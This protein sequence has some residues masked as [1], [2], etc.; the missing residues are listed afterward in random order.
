MNDAILYFKNN[1]IKYDQIDNNTLKINNENYIICTNVPK[2]NEN[3]FYNKYVIYENTDKIYGLNIDKD[4]DDIELELESNNSDRAFVK[5]NNDDL[6]YCNLVS[7]TKIYNFYKKLLI[8][9]ILIWSNDNK[10]IIECIKYKNNVNKILKFE[11]I[12]SSIYV[13]DYKIITYPYYP[14]FNIWIDKIPNIFLLEKKNDNLVIKLLYIP[15][16][17]YDFQNIVLN[18]LN[19]ICLCTDKI[20]CDSCKFAVKLSRNHNNFKHDS[21]NYYI[22]DI[23]YSGLFLSFSSDIIKD[24]FIYD[25]ILYGGKERII[26]LNNMINNNDKKLNE[27]IRLFDKKKI[28]HIPFIEP[29]KKIPDSIIKYQYKYLDLANDLFSDILNV[30]DFEL[31]FDQKNKISNI[32]LSYVKLYVNNIKNCTLKKND[33]DSE[34]YKNQISD[35]FA[36]NNINIY[37][38]LLLN[39]NIFNFFIDNYD[40]LL[41]LLEIINIYNV[42]NNLCIIYKNNDINCQE[43]TKLKQT[44]DSSMYYDNSIDSINF[45]IY[46]FESLAGFF[47][48]PAQSKIF[49][50]ILSD[51]NNN[52]CNIYQM[53]MGTGKTSTITPLL[54]LFSLL[55]IDKNVIINCPKHLVK[56]TYDLLL[57]KFMPLL[58][59][60]KIHKIDI[61]RNDNGNISIY[62]LFTD[63]HKNIIIL[64]EVSIKS[65]KLNMVSN[66]NKINDEK[67]LLEYIKD[68]FII[69]D[70]I[71]SLIEPLKSDLNFPLN[72]PIINKYSKIAFDIMFPILYDIYNYKSTNKSNINLYA[73]NLIKSDEYSFANKYF[74]YNYAKNLFFG[75]KLEWNNQYDIK[76][77]GII[78]KILNSIISAIHLTYN[79]NFGFGDII[80]DKTNGKNYLVAIPYGAI[81]F[82]I[83]GSEFADPE[84]TIA[85]T[86]IS[87]LNK[88]LQKHN[89]KFML[90]YCNYVKIKYSTI[91]KIILFDYF[92]I[93]ETEILCD[94]NQLI[95]CPTDEEID[96]VFDKI[97]NNTQL[98]KLYIQN[99]ILEKYIKIN[100]EQYNCSYIDII[101]DDFTNLKTGYSGTVNFLVPYLKDNGF[102]FNRDIITDN[103]STGGIICAILGIINPVKI[104]P[105][106][107]DPD[108]II[109][110][111]IK[112]DISVFIDT[113]AFFTKVQPVD[114]IKKI[115]QYSITINC[116]KYKNK[117][118]IFIDR[119]TSKKLL[120]FD[121][122]D[123]IISVHKDTIYTHDDIFMYYDNKNIVGA[124]IKQSYKLI[125]LATISQNCRYTNT[126]QGI[127][128]LRNLNYGHIIHFL[129]SN[130]IQNISNTIDLFNFLNFNE[131][132]YK[133]M[134]NKKFAVQNLKTLTRYSKYDTE[135]YTDI[136]FRE[137]NYIHEIRDL[138]I[139]LYNSY[140][141]NLFDCNKT[142]TLFFKDLCT[143]FKNNINQTNFNEINVAKETEIETKIQI[144]NDINLITNI[145]TNNYKFSFNSPLIGKYKIDQ[146]I[147]INLQQCDSDI[148]KFLNKYNIFLS[149]HIIYIFN[150]NNPNYTNNFLPIY[151]NN[152]TNINHIISYSYI[153]TNSKILLISPDELNI[154]L[155]YLTYS[156]RL[157]LPSDL[158]IKNKFQ[159]VFYPKNKKDN[160]I[161]LS[162]KLLKIFLSVDIFF[163][164]YTEIFK[165]FDNSD[166][167]NFYKTVKIMSNISAPLYSEHIINFIK[168]NKNYEE[169]IIDLY[170]KKH[171]AHLLKLC[172]GFENINDIMSKN[173]IE[174][175]II[176]GK[177]IKK[178]SVQYNINI[179]NILSK[180]FKV[181]KY[182]EIIN[183]KY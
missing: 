131:E 123:Y 13:D 67:N 159:Y 32:E 117:K 61:T 105:H 53:L 25:C 172:I 102:H 176:F 103:V 47:V 116:D 146:Y 181:Y 40:I 130:E 161:N 127:F 65:L 139:D 16:N 119:D 62:N 57:N 26:L 63:D 154:I 83:N 178:N 89:I 51:I 9:D 72:E 80:N 58:H 12:N 77:I 91:Y 168:N 36:K 141:I 39:K 99:N 153:K 52:K 164:D 151:Y 71:D 28:E 73:N 149:P 37:N 124:D 101:S 120:Y 60:I 169:I 121:G 19:K 21:N 138:E 125:G 108:D 179:Q 174:N 148:F 134:N 15:H 137:I 4:L 24:Y 94:L 42:Y 59:N 162:E 69:I 114:F 35:I 107:T 111:I 147:N 74:E 31:K 98:I 90:D 171:F 66:F 109:K 87:Y 92:N 175:D 11:Y 144:D 156:K 29:V 64:D 150:K 10:C 95:E 132:N 84:L 170:N 104:I 133:G 45:I 112:N 27:L 5:K 8:D 93:F 135:L 1:N 115:I 152:S 163:Y 118:Y 166:Y 180:I 100:T 34:K 76:I 18:R 158:F 165:N 143:I 142:S 182:K 79:E 136:V 128:R 113:G 3:I 167:D 49:N 43:L 97:K 50:N 96:K 20:Q 183:L 140:I 129:I 177:I 155:Y 86:I 56:Q 173:I 54:V 46:L 41:S 145:V 48:R 110:T 23:H 14:N 160:D 70:E 17:N 157:N 33:F 85:L 44:I 126:A 78:K 55:Y 82:P 106:S 30:I 68:C 38:K 7:D 22:I 6:Y 81:D 75:T 2:E 88:G 122:N